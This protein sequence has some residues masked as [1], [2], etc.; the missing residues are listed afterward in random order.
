MAV[1]EL[2][3]VCV[4]EVVVGEVPVPRGETDEEGSDDVANV[5]GDERP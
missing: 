1:L 4:G 2:L 3:H 5:R